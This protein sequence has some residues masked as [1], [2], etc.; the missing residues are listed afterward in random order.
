MGLNAAILSLGSVSS[1]WTYERMQNYFDEVDEL[2]IKKIQVQLGKENGIYYEGEPLKQYDCIYAKGSYKYAIVLRALTSM[3]AGKCFMPFKASAFTVG[4]NKILTQLKLQQAGI[5][6]PASYLSPSVESAKKVLE[7]ITYPV[8]IKFP[9]GT[10]GKGV[11]FADSYASASSMLDAFATLKQPVIIQEY[12]ETG[13]TDTRAIV[14]GDKVVAAMQRKAET[15]EKRANIHAGGIGE[16]VE[17]DPHAKK[18]AVKTAKAM[19]CGVCA[20]D[21]LESVKGPYVIEIN[22]SPGLQGITSTTKVDVADKIAKYLYNETKNMLSEESSNGKENIFKDLGIDMERNSQEIIT[23]AD[24]RG[25]RLLLPDVITRMGQISEDD[26][27]I[28]KA[29]KG[30]ISITKA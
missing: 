13:S 15:G 20:V 19:N 1:K 8:I 18:I 23:S 11:M 21:L 12:V 4:H 28:I 17:L 14:V 3:M 29:E 5:P 27:I 22:L 9:E 24:L 25:E 10:Q 16:P 2:D 30:R 7:E 26:E 6:T